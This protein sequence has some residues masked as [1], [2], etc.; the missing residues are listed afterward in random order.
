MDAYGVAS[1]REVNP[2]ELW[3]ALFRL[4]GIMHWY[5]RCGL[6]PRCQ[7]SQLQC[8][9]FRINFIICIENG[10]QVNIEACSFPLLINVSPPELQ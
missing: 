4:S 3:W 7:S 2:S 5:V 8:A 1:Y 10:E 9:I 6:L